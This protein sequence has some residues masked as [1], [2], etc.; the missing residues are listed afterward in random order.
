MD[1]QSHQQTMTFHIR[2]FFPFFEP[3]FIEHLL[4]AII[5]GTE[6]V[7]VNQKIPHRAK[8]S[9]QQIRRLLSTERRQYNQD[10]I[11]PCGMEPSFAVGL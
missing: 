4:C 1:P 6:A 11:L 10:S 3:V 2:T 5:L 7:E 9:P 8:T